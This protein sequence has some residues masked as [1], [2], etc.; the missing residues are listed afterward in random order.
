MNAFLL[1]ALASAPSQ[2]SEL[3][4]AFIESVLAG[5][6][7]I[8]IQLVSPDAMATIDALIEEDPAALRDVCAVFGLASFVP[9]PLTDAVDFL[10]SILSSPTVP[11]MIVFANPAPGEPFTTSGRTFVPVTWGI[12]GMRDTLFVEATG[13]SSQGW[14][15]L[16]FFTVDPRSAS[17]HRRT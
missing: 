14:R 15:I 16:D 17:G 10:E 6:S 1:V 12:P 13:S 5:E 9:E 8:A 3:V 11:A 7:A 2:S 4:P